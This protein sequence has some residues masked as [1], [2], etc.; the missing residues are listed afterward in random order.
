MGWSKPNIQPTARDIL[1][2]AKPHIALQRRDR[3]AVM[4]MADTCGCTACTPSWSAPQANRS[5]LFA[6]SLSAPRWSPVV[7]HASC[8]CW[9]LGCHGAFVPFRRNLQVPTCVLY[10]TPSSAGCTAPRDKC[11][12]GF[13]FVCKIVPR[14]MS[15]G[16]GRRSSMLTARSRSPRP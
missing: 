7:H 8:L 4:A 3:A 13:F 10:T 16:T 11:F 12:P 5:L 9:R 15:N 1:L 2:G 14:E 6:S